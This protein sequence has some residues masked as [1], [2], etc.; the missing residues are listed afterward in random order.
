VTVSNN[1]F[2]PANL[3]VASGGRVTWTWDSCAK[4]PYGDPYGGSRESCVSHDVTFDQ[5]GGGSPVQSSGTFS[6][7]FTTPGTYAYH[8]SIHGSSMSGQVVVR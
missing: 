5:G 8:C 6:R 7:T 4:D 3:A 1:A 2:S